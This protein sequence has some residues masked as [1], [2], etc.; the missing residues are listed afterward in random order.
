MRKSWVV[1]C[2]IAVFLMSGVSVLAISE[3]E[4]ILKD[5]TS[6]QIQSNN[7]Y[8]LDSGCTIDFYISDNEIVADAYSSSYTSVDN[9]YV[10]VFI[11]K[12]TN[13]SWKTVTS[14]SDSENDSDFVKT[15][16]S[17]T[18]KQKG[19]Y[20]AYAIHKI[21]HNGITEKDVTYTSAIKIN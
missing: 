3:E 17:M 8:L 14:G 19:E 16:L 11:Q 5:G 20:R 6:I 1:L 15:Y 18:P 9:I 2:I 4:V 7:E 10:K 12:Y 21:T 13:G